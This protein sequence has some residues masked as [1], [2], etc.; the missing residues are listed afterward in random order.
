[1]SKKEIQ[2]TKEGFEIFSRIDYGYYQN[3]I[4]FDSLGHDDYVRK[5]TFW[6]LLWIIPL[7]ATAFAFAWFVVFFYFMFPEQLVIWA[8]FWILAL[9]VGFLLP[10]K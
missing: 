2:T 3:P 6:D 8:P 4:F 5:F 1:M 10:T 9:L 7:C